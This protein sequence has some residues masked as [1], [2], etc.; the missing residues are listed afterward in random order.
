MIFPDATLGMIGGGQLGRMFT[1]AARSM[2]YRVI[3]LDPD[4]HSP[5][6]NIADQH[7]QADFHDHAALDMLGDSCVAITSE[8][9]NLPV[10]SLS[11][12]QHHCPV[13]PAPK[14]LAMAQNR[15][16]EK[17]FLD[18]HEFPTV[19]FYPIQTLDDLEEA[20]TGLAA[21]GIL[22]IAEPRYPGHGRHAVAN[23]EEAAEAFREM[24]E[25]PCIL[26]ERIYIEKRLSV[27]LARSIEGEIAVYPVV[28]NRYRKGILDLSLAPADISTVAADGAIEL[29]CELA[30]E[31]EYCGVLSVE[32][33]LT[34]DGEL[35]VNTIT[36][37]PHNSGNFTV[38]A[39]V[40]SQFEQQVR[41][42]CGL[43]PGDTQLLTSV[44]MTNLLGDLWSRGDP[45]WEP[46][47]HEPQ[48]KLHLYGKQEARPGRKMGHINCLAEDTEGALEIAESIR[49][50]LMP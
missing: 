14:V 34:G 42:M 3:I 9:E 49:K 35:R 25:Q 5:A 4:P 2:G 46:V 48:A 45:D 1:I 37:R 20:M 8:F 13:H 43:P 32:F 23:L 6:G 30:D 22:K 47:F 16:L 10:E 7:I 44:V 28:E 31:L 17:T 50:Q 29:A 15:L 21:P 11:R 38:D 41:M 40:T 33:F 36:P 26:E 12:L 19:A 27:I 18:D 24:E 39:C